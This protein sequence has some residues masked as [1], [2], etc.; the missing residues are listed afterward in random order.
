M[1]PRQSPARSVRTM[2]AWK[3]R[4]SPATIFRGTNLPSAAPGTRSAITSRAYYTRSPV[5]S[6]F[7][8][9]Q[10]R[11]KPVTTMLGL[12]DRDVLVQIDVLNRIQQANA[13]LYRPLE[14][15]A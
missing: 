5:V 9:T 15:L 2:N 11:L 12:R 6:A 10:G 8:R 4:S 7:R 14:G 13:L 3:R 1:P